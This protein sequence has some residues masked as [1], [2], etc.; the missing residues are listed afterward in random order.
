MT[1]GP[2]E[3][4]LWKPSVGR[5]YRTALVQSWTGVGKAAQEKRPGDPRLRR[6]TGARRPAKGCPL[7]LQPDVF[8]PG[9]CAQTH[10]AKANVLLQALDD[11]PT[12]HLTVT[13]SFAKYLWL[14]LDDAGQEFGIVVVQG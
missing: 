9:D 11:A 1:N 5:S 10:L 7:D 8:R 13:R 3:S 2:K 14:W 4:T 6:A 12:F